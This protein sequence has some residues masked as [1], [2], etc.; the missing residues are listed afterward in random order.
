[1]LNFISLILDLIVVIVVRT[2]LN[3]PNFVKTDDFRRDVDLR[4]QMAPSTISNFR[5]LNLFS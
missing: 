2:F 4:W 3:L 5:K 1:M